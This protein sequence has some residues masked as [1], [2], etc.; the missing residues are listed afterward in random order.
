MMS[1][2]KVGTWQTPSLERMDPIWDMPID[3]V[4][5]PVRAHRRK[6]SDIENESDTTED[7]IRGLDVH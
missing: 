3:S 2:I 1:G 7:Q 6:I 5:V 4:K